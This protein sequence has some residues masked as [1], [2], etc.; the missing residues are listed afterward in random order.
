MNATIFS[1]IFAIF[2]L[3]A[4]TV[5]VAPILVVL[6]GE[7]PDWWPAPFRR[8]RRFVVLMV[9]RAVGPP[10]LPRVLRA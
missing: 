6:G 5:A 7:D 4:I 2:V 8:I 9:L 1:L 3:T 10:V